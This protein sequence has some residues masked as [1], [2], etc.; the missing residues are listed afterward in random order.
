MTQKKKFNKM[1]ITN[2]KPFPIDSEKSTKIL[3][4]KLS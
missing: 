1:H 2:L 4:A 3:G